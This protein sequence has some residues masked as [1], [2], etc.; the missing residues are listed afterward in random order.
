MLGQA[1]A[2]ALHPPAD[3]APGPAQVLAP[4]VAGPQLDPVDHEREAAEAP[5]DS[6]RPAA[7]STGTR[8]CG[9]RR[10]GGRGEAGATAL[11]P[12]HERRAGCGGGRRRVELHP[13]PDGVDVH[14]AELGA[15]SA[16]PLV[17]GQYV[18]S[19]LGGQALREIAVPALGPT[20]GVGVQAVVDEA[21]PHGRG[22]TMPVRQS[23]R[24]ASSSRV[25]SFDTG[26]QGR[27]RPR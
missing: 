16:R 21:D 6:P 17:E 14:A 13:G 10:S 9:R 11:P 20:D 26:G 27:R 23:A 24:L 22:D 4:V 15:L 18:T 2:E 1:H 5:R 19:C 12:E 8:L 7:R 3:R 25:M